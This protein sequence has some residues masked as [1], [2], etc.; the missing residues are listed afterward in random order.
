M[1]FQKI[2]NYY[3]RE[4][5]QRALLEIAQ[6][7]EVVQVF[8]EGT[9]GKRPDLIQYPSDIV[10]GI[11]QG[12]VS[13][14]GSLERWSQPMK[15]EVSLSK[16]EFD[17]LRVGW[18]ILIDPDVSDFEI[19]K[20]TTLQIIEA[21]KDHGLHNFSLKYSGG[22]G[23]HVG[24]PFESLP[25][26]INFQATRFLFPELL[27]KVI[28]YTKWYVKE[29]L[30]DELLRFDSPVNI[31]QRVGKKLAEITSPDGL[32]PFRVVSMDVFSHR[33][34]FRLPYSLHEKSLLVSTPVDKKD[35]EGF[36]KSDAQPEKIKVE[37]KFLIPR[38]KVRDAEGLVIE[39]MDW[40]S[41]NQVDIKEKPPFKVRFAKTSPIPEQFFPPCI[42]RILTGIPDGRKRSV[43]I[44]INFLKNVGWD[45][46]KI[47]KRIME[48]N[49]KN[50]PPLRANY[51]RSQLRWHFRQ[52]K[53]LLPPNCENQNFYRAMGIDVDCLKLHEEGIKNPVNFAFR[54]MKQSKHS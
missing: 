4:S 7:R 35:L 44:M 23:F 38:V 21:L 29:N 27:Q 12:A 31:A 2:W 17:S 48:W 37:E 15:L 30:K 52:D 40:A 36:E 53:N 16:A 20:I 51:L 5:V 6:N 54:K 14:H 41:K 3:S 42:Q 39:A 45:A 28:E 13:F 43:F 46:E 9:F 18:D 8:E 11:A 32:E 49:E 10:Q 1:D 22:K 47:E 33:H 24:I 34:L 25:E 26:K 19:A 50:N